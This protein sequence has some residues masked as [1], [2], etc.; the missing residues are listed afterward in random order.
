MKQEENLITENC[1]SNPGIDGTPFT[2]TLDKNWLRASDILGFI[3]GA[4]TSKQI[5]KNNQL[6]KRLKTAKTQKF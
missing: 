1:V 2:I 4:F 3:N 5:F 6:I